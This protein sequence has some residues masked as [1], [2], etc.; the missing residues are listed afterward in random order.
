MGLDQYAF[1]ICKCDNCDARTEIMYW[2]KHYK[3][4]KYMQNLFE[5]KVGVGVGFYSEKLFLTSEDL[6]KLEK[7][8]LKGQ[9]SENNWSG[10]REKDLAFI[11]LAK[12]A[13]ED[14]KRVYYQSD[15]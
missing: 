13:I 8:I 7:V 5:E 6:D 15:W 1:S 4:Q 12:I 9:L 10:E 11:N 14:G 2:R 3:L